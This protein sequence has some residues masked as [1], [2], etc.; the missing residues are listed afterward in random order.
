[1]EGKAVRNVRMESVELT[2]VVY[3]LVVVRRKVYEMMPVAE[4]DAARSRGRAVRAFRGLDGTANR[5]AWVG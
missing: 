4:P 1:M 3:R 2:A 5:Q